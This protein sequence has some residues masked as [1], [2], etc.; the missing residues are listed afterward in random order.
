M[1]FRSSLRLRL[2]ALYSGLF[3][4]MG[5]VLLAV[6][7]LLATRSFGNVLSVPKTDGLGGPLRPPPAD[8]RRIA[9]TLR[10]AELDRLLTDSILALILTSAVS[11]LFG[12]LMAGRALRPIHRITATARR[13]SSENLHER[14]ALAG[15]A[16]ELKDL[17]D[18]FDTML[19]RL[20]RA[21][22][23]QK[24]FIA[25][26]SHELRTPLAI[27]RA[28]LQIRLPQATLADLPRIQ[29]ELL[30]ANRR[31]ER[32][33]E[34]LLQLATSDRGLTQ[35]EPVDLLA[36]VTDVLDSHHDEITEAGLRLR[37]DLQ[38]VRCHGDAL[39]LTQLVRNLVHNAIRH[40][41][42]GGQLEVHTSAGAGLVV[43]NTGPMIAAERVEELFEPFRRLA[44]QRTGSARGA[45]LGLS[46]AKSIATAHGGSIHAR[47]GEHGGL[48]VR[49][50][51]P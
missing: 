24:R 28:V 27:Q 34:G 51:L 11:V 6:T 5:T 43:R 31:S 49:V 47:P 2:T 36:V 37:R 1:R 38:P 46:I 39:L 4:V 22:D 14:V 45:G 8:L 21:F 9:L 42:P 18:T 41:V 25:N 32:L 29:E 15:P 16:D 19:D 40:N 20:D 17:A 13:L 44:P 12:W 30:V 48:T 33:I 10:E 7:Y 23:S 3:L 35:R 26:A 50:S